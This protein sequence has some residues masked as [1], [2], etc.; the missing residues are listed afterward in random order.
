MVPA[1]LGTLGAAKHISGFKVG[2]RLSFSVKDI[3]ISKTI[4]E[5]LPRTPSEVEISTL[6]YLKVPIEINH[7]D[8]YITP[9]V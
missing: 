9:S 5:K 8:L 7:N 1:A 6:L 4:S 2:R 3:S